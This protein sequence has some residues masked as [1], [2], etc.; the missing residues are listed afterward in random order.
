MIGDLSRGA[1]GAWIGLRTRWRGLALPV[2]ASSLLPAALFAGIGGDERIVTGS[3]LGFGAS[4]L[5][6]RI[7]RRGR[8]G[9]ANRAAWIM[10]VG[11]GLAAQAV[12]ERLLRFLDRVEGGEQG[13]GWPFGRDVHASELYQVLEEAPEIDHVVSLELA[14]ID[15]PDRGERDRVRLEATE[16]VLAERD[17]I[18][19]TVVES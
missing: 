3:A 5:A 9:D 19:V 2:F 10:A 17:D 14:A 15:P 18:D 13:T 12:R 11:T 16:L 1:L 7:L 6:A 8:Q 4:L